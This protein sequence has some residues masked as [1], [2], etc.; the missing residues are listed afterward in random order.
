MALLVTPLYHCW[1][2]GS[3]KGHPFPPGD[4]AGTLL[5]LSGLPQHLQPGFGS[6]VGVEVTGGEEEGQRWSTS[7]W[8]QRILP[9]TLQ[10]FLI[11]KI[12]GLP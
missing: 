9:Q 10:F 4:I 6:L 8:D 11:K 3:G 12:L 5:W 2:T 7:L 1:E